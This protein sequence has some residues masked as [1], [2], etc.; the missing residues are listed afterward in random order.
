MPIN[1]YL[2]LFTLKR[3][4]MS[5]ISSIFG[6]F[7][8]NDPLPVY[9]LCGKFG[10]FILSK[11]ILIEKFDNLIHSLWS[12]KWF[13]CNWTH[14]VRF[15]NNAYWKQ[16]EDHTGER[17]ACFGNADAIYQGWV[18]LN[19]ILFASFMICA[20]VGCVCVWVS[21]GANW[22]LV[23]IRQREWLMKW[24]PRTAKRYIVEAATGEL[25]WLLVFEAL[26][27]RAIYIYMYVYVYMYIYLYKLAIN[28]YYNIL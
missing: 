27:W 28:F 9:R 12:Y 26:Q 4:F 11:T 17:I 8:I 7:I 10:F 13:Q 20:Y 15:Y 1:L 22:R 21:A 14:N 6:N 19:T 2:S 5:S 25:G 16:Q 23:S 24:S 18:S 3:Q